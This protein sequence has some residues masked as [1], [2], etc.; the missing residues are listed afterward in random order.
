MKFN[1]PA[2]SAGISLGASFG[3]EA[4]NLQL[5][6]LRFDGN[7]HGI[8]SRG[9]NWYTFVCIFD[10]QYQ[11][12]FGQSAKDIWIENSTFSN[13]RF[14][15]INISSAQNV[16]ILQN[17]IT[18]TKNGISLG[19][20]GNP[21]IRSLIANNTVNLQGSNVEG[22]RISGNK[23]NVINNSAQVRGQ[24]SKGIYSYDFGTDVDIENNALSSD[25]GRALE[26]N[27]FS[28][29]PSKKINYNS[30]YTEG[31]F[32]VKMAVDYMTLSE[33][34]SAYPGYNQYS[35]NVNPHF[36]QDMHTQSPWLRAAGTYR[37]EI[38]TDMDDEPRGISF[39][40]GADQQT[41]NLIDTRLRGTYTIGDTGC[42]YA[43]IQAALDDLELHGIREDVIFNISPGVYPGNNI[44]RHFPISIASQQVYFNALE[45]VSF[46]ML[47]NNSANENYFFRLVGVKNLNFT[48]LQMEL[49]A[50]NRQSTFFVLNGRCEN[51]SI[52]ESSFNLYNPLSSSNTA[53]S[54]EGFQ[55]SN[56]L[57]Q[58]CNFE[59]GDKGISIP[60]PYNDPTSYTGVEIISNTFSN[61]NYPISIQKA[62]DLEIVAN[63]MN[64]AIQAISLSNISGSTKI[65]RNRIVSSGFTGSYS[66][67]T[68]VNMTSCHGDFGS[69]LQIT[70]NII[71]VAQSSAQSITALAI[72]GS[73]H[74][75]LGN[76]TIISDNSTYGENGAALSLSNLSIFSLWNNIISA[77]ASGYAATINSCTY[78]NLQNNAWYGSGKYVFKRDGILYTAQELLDEI[79]PDGYFANPLPNANGYSQCSY[80]RGKG[81]ENG[82]NGDIDN[83]WWNGAPDIGAS[84]IPDAGSPFSGTIYAGLFEEY[85]D[86]ASA[87]EALQKRGIDSDVV[88]QLIS[89][90]MAS[91][92]ILGY[93]PNSLEYSITIRGAESGYPSTLSKTASTEAD[94]YI[95]KLYN[96]RNL[97]LQN[98]SFNAGNPTYSKCVELQR[99][100][101]NLEILDCKFQTAA[102]SQ[103]SSYSAALYTS[104]AMLEDCKMQDSIVQNIPRGISITGLQN[105]SID[106]TGIYIS[107]N[108]LTGNHTAISLSY[109]DSPQVLGNII[110]DYRGNGI[111]ASTGVKNLSIQTNQVSGNGQ[112][113]FLSN[114]GTGN[115]ELINNFVSTGLAADTSIKVENSPN[116]R[117]FHNTII[118]SSANA[119]AAAFYQGSS[120]AGLGFINNI[121][122]AAA[123]YAAWFN[124]YSDFVGG[125]WTYNLFHSTGAN[126]IRLGGIDINSIAD[127]NILVGDWHNI[128]ADPLLI[129]GGFELPANSPA[130]D[131]GIFLPFVA[132]DILG[133]QRVAHSDL[134]CYEY[135]LSSLPA[136]H[137]LQISLS[138]DQG[139]ITLSWD[140]VAGAGA[141]YVQSASDPYA[142]VWQ[143]VPGASTDQLTI[144]LPVPSEAYLFYRVVA[145]DAQ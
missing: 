49:Q 114:L 46:S 107:G 95:L 77:P 7:G 142:L 81:A 41:G 135:Q 137:N 61:V 83:H 57:V 122:V 109:V 125:M 73:S 139:Q 119:N 45:G 121:T 82:T 86:L 108:N 42:N 105:Q 47:P 55:G 8:E 68:M 111:Y 58:N 29:D 62:V 17:R 2:N 98:V 30:Y 16:T 130:R 51:I 110:D 79:D 117:L 141:Y 115:H 36:T 56:L 91:S 32:L 94:N 19:T 10:N 25:L 103:T 43:S 131:A 65:R 78:Y 1:A 23:M 128:M 112:G 97:K 123:G 132:Q 38:S 101:N 21:D 96:T 59:D 27:N 12:F 11:G 72:T 54:T 24:S 48:G 76:N 5:F 63:I 138:P 124:Q 74:M 118:N 87:W 33:L 26:I 106:N 18:G 60:G 85:P 88:L 104:G 6:A 3:S 66:S 67:Y 69:A 92:A 134:G 99:Y 64:S 113:I 52:T 84:I 4:D 136:P 90:P 89:G 20:Y 144:S 28:P 80:L 44:V 145:I 102:N 70:N 75:Y 39:D 50:A 120:S 31:N 71:N 35:I 9:S 34:Q 100:T 40:I 14:F 143:N 126:K 127:L 93:V 15:S 116:V 133:Q 37:T 22:I 13:A 140:S 129:D 53:I